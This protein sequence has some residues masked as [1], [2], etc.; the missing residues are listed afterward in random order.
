MWK[1]E[2]PLQAVNYCKEVNTSRFSDRTNAEPIVSFN[3]QFSSVFVI[4]CNCASVTRYFELP[5]NLHF[6]RPRKLAQVVGAD[7]AIQKLPFCRVV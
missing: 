1:V 7:D 6:F 3:P 4:L 5:G 2:T